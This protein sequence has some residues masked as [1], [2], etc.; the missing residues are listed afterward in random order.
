MRSSPAKQ[1]ASILLVALALRLVVGWGWQTRLDGPFLFGDSESYW[2]LARAIAHGEPYQLGEARV[3]RTPGYPLLLAPLFFA[4]GGE[5]SV[6]WARAQSALFGTLSV[7]GV[8]WLGRQLFSARAGLVAASIAAVYPGAV[9]MGVLVL[10]EAPFCPLMLLHLILWT[11]AWKAG[12]GKH[13]AFLSGCAG[14]VGG[15]ATLVRPSWLLFTPF[16][17][18]VGLIL[19]DRRR[20]LAVG[21]AMLAGLV[22]AMMPWWIRNAAVT[23]RFVPTTLQVGASL[24]DGWNPEATGAS[25]MGFVGRIA[26][27]ELRQPTGGPDAGHDLFEYRLDRRLRAESLAW[28]R[29]HPGRVAALVWIKA[30][31]TWNFWPNEAAFSAWPLRLA[32]LLTYVPVM[33]LAVLGAWKTIHRGWPYVL[34]WL[35]AVY[36]TLLH[37]VFVSSIRYRQPAMLALMILAAGAIVSRGGGS[38][39]NDP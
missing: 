6:M 37:V 24:Y 31:R 8:W 28:A 39:E 12:S 22:L 5:P 14:L 27:A 7:A 26:E 20:H 23:G 11:A 29:S 25:N 2:V 19:G 33:V 36:F 18:M 17:V 9:A 16:A 21:A 10:S 13:V 15:A 32:V 38:E 1:L 35:P 4:P 3:F 30:A 34:C